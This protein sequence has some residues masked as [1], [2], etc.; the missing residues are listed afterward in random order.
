M[1]ESRI[2]VDRDV[3]VPMRDGAVLRADVYRPDGAR[4]CPL[5]LE[6]TP[7]DKKARGRPGVLL[8]AL[9]YAEQGYVVVQDTRGR[10]A[11]DGEF[12]PF[13]DEARDGADTIAWAAGLPYASGR[14]GLFGASYA[15]ATQWLAA[16]AAPPALC[17]MAPAR[18]AADYHQPWAYQGGVLQLGFLLHW[19]LSSLGPDTARRLVA[20]GGVPTTLPARLG[21]AIDEFE[22]LARERPPL[23]QGSLAEVAAAAL[24]YFHDWMA[25]PTDDAYWQAYDVERQ[26]AGVST[27]TLHIGGWYDIFIQGTLR[28]FSA[29]QGRPRAAGGAPT[30]RLIVG[31]WAHGPMNDTVGGLHF[32]VAAG[33]DAAGVGTMLRQWFDAWLRGS[34]AALVGQAPVRLFVMGA[35][36]WRD[37]QEWPLARAVPTRYYLHAGGALSAEAPGHEAPETYFYD[38]ADPAPTRGGAT[39]MAGHAVNRNAGPRDQRPLET[40]PDVLVYTSEP[41]AEPLEVT[42]PLTVEL[43]ASSSAEDTDWVARLIDVQP[44][45]Y[46]ALLAEGILRARYRDGT[47]EPAFLEP[48]RVYR[49]EI[50]LVAT[51]NVFRAGHRLRVHA[52]SSSFPRFAPNPNLRVDNP[53]LDPTP[54]QVA[55]QT[56]YH[57]AGYP[58]CIVL[59]VVAA[60]R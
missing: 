51:S 55:R 13:R 11:S 28:A 8:D 26:L 22:D 56:I 9:R 12:Y 15:G 1:A 43:Y 54:P 31:P 14:V 37:E 40:R 6:R 34:E 5:L 3:P 50:D 45:G 4:D 33:G 2:V 57:G 49:F 23:A 60:E 39:L 29:L 46:A 7:Y 21:R 48:G 25:H 10:F 27:P 16:S 47:A 17:A 44:D 41:L 24:P 59:P 53:Y 20:A 19:A 52:T 36:V 32:G 58:S 30:Q 42:G 35:N 38:P 18:T